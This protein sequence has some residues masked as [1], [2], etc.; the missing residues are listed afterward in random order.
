LKQ[1]VC[2][3]GRRKAKTQHIPLPRKALHIPHNRPGAEKPV[4]GRHIFLSSGIPERQ[5]MSVQPP[6]SEN[7]PRIIPALRHYNFSRTRNFFP[8]KR[9]QKFNF[10]RMYGSS[11]SPKFGCGAMRMIHP[12]A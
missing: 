1:T 3:S 9:L 4:A 8:K 11:Y 2:H 12:S 6:Q 5:I 7:L 10:Y